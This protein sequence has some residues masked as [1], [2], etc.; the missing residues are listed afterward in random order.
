MTPRDVL[1]S[2]AVAV[3]AGVLVGAEREQAQGDA[4]QRDF[5]GIRTFPLIALLGALGAL[6]E[7]VGSAWILV[8]FLFAFV[9]L[10]FRS[11]AGGRPDNP[12]ITSEVAAI[13]TFALG[14]V[15]ASPELMP[16]GP[17]WLLVV[18]AAAVTMTLLAVKRPL[19]G[20]IAVVSQEDTYATAKFVLLALVVL[21]LLPN[22]AYG[23]FDALNPFKIGVFIVLVAG[24]SFAGYV[25]A[26]LVGSGRGLLLVGLIGGIVSSTAVTLTLAG[27]ARKE[28]ALAGSAAIAIVAA[29]ATMFAR[30]LVVIGIVH[31]PLLARL[32]LPLA[33][34]AVTGFG[35]ALIAA[36]RSKKGK[37]AEGVPL[38]NP[39]ELRSALTFGLYY[40]LIAFVAKAAEH[41]A[42][43]SGLYASAVLAG[44]ADVD[45]ITLSFVELHRSG[46]DAAVATT[47]IVLAV[48]TNTLVKVGISAVTG[49]KALGTQVA[50]MLGAVI[51]AGGALVVVQRL[52]VG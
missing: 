29:C 48:I 14:A 7:S 50:L 37:S 26:R 12:G 31:F 52:F 5:G 4:P 45:A 22:R 36:L 30:L 9:A 38:R 35:L 41:Y 16:N 21:P 44:L 18:G 1:L 13:V 49:G 3:A 47:G 27:R 15:A 8:G 34:M 40:A 20:F 24:V 10:L 11:R 25:A 33:A 23:P 39:F 32:A 43:S 17:R 2:L 28:P 51:V 42:G 46:L 6:L 19:H